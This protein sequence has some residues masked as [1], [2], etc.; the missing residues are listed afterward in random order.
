MYYLQS[1]ESIIRRFIEQNPY[2]RSHF[3]EASLPTSMLLDHRP[4]LRRNFESFCL[5]W[6][7]ASGNNADEKILSI[8]SKLRQ[9][10]NHLE[11]FND[12]K[13]CIDYIKCIENEK[14]ILIICDASEEDILSEIHDWPQLLAVY[15]IFNHETFAGHMEGNY[16]KVSQ[17]ETGARIKLFALVL[18]NRFQRYDSCFR[19]STFSTTMM[20]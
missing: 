20:I 1:L 15:L 18:V 10:I 16:K 14:V 13:E 17:I 7:S 5:V 8:Q 2:A 6:L 19:S 3:T 9:A 11:L 12:P 4:P